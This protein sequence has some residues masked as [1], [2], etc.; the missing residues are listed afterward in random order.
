MPRE[1]FDQLTGP[2]RG[3]SSC[4]FCQRP[5]LFKTKGKYRWWSCHTSLYEAIIPVC[6]KS[7]VRKE[8][9]EQQA[10]VGPFTDEQCKEIYAKAWKERLR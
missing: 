1:T 3:P 8:Y 10:V 6:P 5:N 9:R 7:I 2:G 4:V